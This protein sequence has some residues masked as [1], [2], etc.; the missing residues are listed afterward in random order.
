MTKLI[1]Y[2]LERANASTRTKLHRELYGYRDI[3]CHGRYVYQREGL[4]HKLKF[5]RVIDSV[6]L[7]TRKDAPKILKVLKRYGA[8]AH[9]FEVKV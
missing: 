5:K 6:M 2:S 7:T 8:R 4:I 3:S 1:C 9:I